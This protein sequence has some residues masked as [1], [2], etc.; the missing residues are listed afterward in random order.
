M[1]TNQ[2]YKNTFYNGLKISVLTCFGPYT[3]QK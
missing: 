3:K 1:V 2:K